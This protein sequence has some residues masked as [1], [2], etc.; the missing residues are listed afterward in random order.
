M[1]AFLC[2]LDAGCQLFDERF[3]LAASLP[4]SRVA[5]PVKHGEDD[6]SSSFDTIEDRIRKAPHLDA[7]YLA[8]LCGVA[9]GL[10]GRAFYGVVNFRYECNPRPAPRSWYQSAAASN[11]ARAAFRKTTFKVIPLV[12]W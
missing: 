12:V 4:D 6:N 8:M 1:R 2:D 9:I 10:L 3:Q 5:P 11:S 7:A